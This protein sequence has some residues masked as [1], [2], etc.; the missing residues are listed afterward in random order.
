[1]DG[2]RTLKL[3]LVLASTKYPSFLPRYSLPVTIHSTLRNSTPLV[4]SMRAEWRKEV[5]NVLKTASCNRCQDTRF[6]LEGTAGPVPKWFQNCENAKT[7][8]NESAHTDSKRPSL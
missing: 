5:R 8:D 4:V 1:M 7:N 6:R 2:G 3:A